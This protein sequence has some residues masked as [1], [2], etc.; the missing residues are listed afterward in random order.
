MHVKAFVPIT[1]SLLG[2]TGSLL[3]PISSVIITSAIKECIKFVI[4][5]LKFRRKRKSK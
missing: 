2:C 1:L 5:L 4:L 3:G